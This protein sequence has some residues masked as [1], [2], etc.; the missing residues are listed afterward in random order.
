MALQSIQL[1]TGEPGSTT[2]PGAVRRLQTMA[3]GGAR[4]SARR[5]FS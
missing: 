3:P 5:N 1:A 4:T 2:E